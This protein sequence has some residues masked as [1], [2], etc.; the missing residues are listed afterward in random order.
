MWNHHVV[1]VIASD[2]K[3]SDGFTLI[4]FIVT[5]LIMI[6]LVSMAAPSFVG[7]L[8]N[9]RLRTLAE[10]FV[11]AID[12]G[13]SNAAM[14]RSTISMC[15]RLDTGGCLVGAPDWGSGWILFNDINGNGI[16]DGGEATLKVHSSLSNS[17]ILGA[18]NTGSVMIDETGAIV[19]QNAG[20]VNTRT[21]KLSDV[22]SSTVLYVVLGRYGRAQ[23]L[24]A[25]Q[26]A[27]VASG[28]VP[29]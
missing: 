20:G 18:G 4:E 5:I 14:L 24:T 6:V 9:T 16:Q 25:S 7:P 13:R 19:S 1:S 11:N 28:C 12:L 23:I 26:C 2:S 21:F 8:A 3:R 29:S 27:Q 17:V 10:D 22:Q 15:P